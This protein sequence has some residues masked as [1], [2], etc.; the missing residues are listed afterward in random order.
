MA[1]TSRGPRRGGTYVRDP[2]TG[3]VKRTGGTEEAPAVPRP[4]ETAPDTPDT[5]K[6]E[7]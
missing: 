4:E 3:R 1:G 5:P 7:G 6:K 2:K